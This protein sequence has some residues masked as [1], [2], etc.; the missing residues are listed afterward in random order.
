VWSARYGGGGVARIDPP[1]KVERFVRLPVEQVSSCAFGGP[2]L[3]T[4]YVTT[5]RQRLTADQLVRQP[6]AGALLAVD[7]DI[8]GLAETAFEG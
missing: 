5:S 4:L 6:L 2:D 1:G 3:T 7:A 8:Q